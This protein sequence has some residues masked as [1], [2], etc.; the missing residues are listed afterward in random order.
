MESAVALTYRQD[1]PKRP[2]IP[3]TAGQCRLRTHAEFVSNANYF[4][5]K[6]HTLFREP[7]ITQKCTALFKTFTVQKG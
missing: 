4:T 2:N 5:N 1:K 7:P 6:N 3:R